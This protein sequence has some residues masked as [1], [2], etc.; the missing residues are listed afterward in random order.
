MN[1]GLVELLQ[2]I[3]KMSNDA[4]DRSE[5]NLKHSLAILKQ[6]NIKKIPVKKLKN[7][8]DWE[9]V[10]VDAGNGRKRMAVF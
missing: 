1:D 10:F 3:N 6:L 5:A 8:N 7:D 2:T 9:F 4:L